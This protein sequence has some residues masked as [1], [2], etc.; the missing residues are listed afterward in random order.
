[1]AGWLDGWMVGWADCGELIIVLS[2]G[3]VLSLAIEEESG[4]IHV[5]T[6][7]V[8]VHPCERLNIQNMKFI[9]K[10]FFIG[11]STI[12]VFFIISCCVF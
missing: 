6:V 5:S 9:H 3:W 2:S 12:K 7:V 11:E 8:L 4:F 1:M 10:I